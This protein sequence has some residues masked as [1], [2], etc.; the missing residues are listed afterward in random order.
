[1][2]IHMSQLYNIY[3]MGEMFRNIIIGNICVYMSLLCRG[4]LMWWSFSKDRIWKMNVTIHRTMPGYTDRE[5]VEIGNALGF[6]SQS[7]FIK[8][9]RQE[10]GFT[11]KEYRRHFYMVPS[12]PEL[13]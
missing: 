6:S 11:P 7:Y 10:T 5:Y 13:G 1:M 12:E 8:V 4:I 3:P 9:F 2:F